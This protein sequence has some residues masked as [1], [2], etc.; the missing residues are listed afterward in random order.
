M[1]AQQ[2]LSCR[3]YRTATSLI[4]KLTIPTAP[5]PTPAPSAG[6]TAPGGLAAS[7]NGSGANQRAAL[8]WVD[9]AS[10]ETGYVITLERGHGDHA[11]KRHARTGLPVRA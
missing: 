6:P 2:H 3:Q 5:T 4:R 10:N 8:T 11:L 7:R 1:G 9:N